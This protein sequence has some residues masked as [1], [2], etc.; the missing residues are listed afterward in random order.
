M[1]MRE[2]LVNLV[3]WKP[4]FSMTYL[5]LFTL[6][7][8]PLAGCSGEGTGG[9]TISSL[10]TPTDAS[11]GLDSNQASQS[12]ATDSDG[13]E[14]PVITMT[15]TP[16]GVTAHVTWV[17]PPDMNVAGYNVYYRKQASAEPSSEESNS[18]EP[19][20]EESS[21]EEPS[22]CSTGQSQ[23]VDG[24]SATIVGLEPNTRYLFAIRAFNEN[25]SESLCSNEIPAVTL[26]AQS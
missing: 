26:P 21:S 20:S 6:L 17:R 24:P 13:E 25:E 22:S 7:L 18:E 23:T 1:L 2:S 10:S 19:V 14:D 3:T 11:A 8:M 16:T 15:S 9:P 5:A 4:T 12:E